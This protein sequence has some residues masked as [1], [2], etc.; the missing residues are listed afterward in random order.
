MTRP[1]SLVMPQLVVNPVQLVIK[2]R[3]RELSGFGQLLDDRRRGS[4]KLIIVQ[5]DEVIKL[6]VK[7]GHEGVRMALL[8]DA[9]HPGSSILPG[10]NGLHFL[11]RSV[12]SLD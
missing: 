4:G 12:R 6:F 11:I 1:P 9:L 3:G 2:L 8:T 5:I 10:K 7:A